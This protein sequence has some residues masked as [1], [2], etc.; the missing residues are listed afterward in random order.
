MA[1]SQPTCSHRPAAL[2]ETT[3]RL[4]S[5]APLLLLLHPHLAGSTW[6]DSTPSADAQTQ[7]HPFVAPRLQ[8][9]SRPKRH[10][11]VNVIAKSDGGYSGPVTL[12]TSVDQHL[13]QCLQSGGLA[14]GIM[15]AVLV[16]ESKE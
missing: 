7:I 11:Y 4:G 3:L 9:K 15:S 10:L 13:K 12:S 6:G 8:A 5:V 16:I 14:D 1:A 2:W